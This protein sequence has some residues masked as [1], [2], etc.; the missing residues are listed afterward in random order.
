MLFRGR[1][2]LMRMKPAV[3]AP[4]FL[5]YVVFRCFALRAKNEKESAAVPERTEG[6]R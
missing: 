6:K 4:G 2:S 3:I 1:A 5:D